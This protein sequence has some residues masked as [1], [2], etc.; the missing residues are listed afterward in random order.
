M[1]KKILVTEYAGFIG[2]HARIA[3]VSARY[4]SIILNNISNSN[5]LVLERL[6]RI[7]KI[8]PEFIKGDIR[9]RFLLNK[10][11]SENSI[12]GVIHFAELN[13]VGEFAGK[14]PDYYDNN[15]TPQVIRGSHL[16]Y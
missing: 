5:S 16:P 7:T 3:L 9:E 6:N 8:Q 15:V 12:S 11:F 2:S 1:K 10:I 14:P 4:L 13:S